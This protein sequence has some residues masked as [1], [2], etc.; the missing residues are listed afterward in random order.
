[1]SISL[2]F[3]SKGNEQL[4]VASA[5]DDLDNDI[6]LDLP[7]LFNFNKRLGICRWRSRDLYCIVG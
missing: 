3:V 7:A 1:V 4:H 5:P 2:E 6:Q